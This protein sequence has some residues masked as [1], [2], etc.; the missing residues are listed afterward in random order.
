MSKRSIQSTSSPESADLIRDFLATHH[1]GV[2]ATADGA[3]NPH[4][5]VVYFSFNN[6]FCLTFATKTET[7]K[8][9]NMEENDQVA[10]ACYDEANQTTVQ[11]TGQVEKVAD[12]AER[13]EML[14]AIY[15]YSASLS[16]TELPPIEKLFAG[17]YVVLRLLPQVIKMAIFLRPDSEGQDMYETILFGQDD[18]EDDRGGTHPSQTS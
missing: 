6:N 16:K 1:S 10:F 7:Q 3:A 12:E 2:L 5:A 13:Q 11:I 17:D 8:Y 9:K 15:D 4:A 14:N 18:G